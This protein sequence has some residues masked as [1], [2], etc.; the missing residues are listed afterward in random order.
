MTEIFL[1]K[2]TDLTKFLDQGNK[3]VYAG[4]MELKWIIKQSVFRDS[5]INGGAKWKAEV[6]HNAVR[7]GLLLGNREE[8]RSHKVA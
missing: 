1:K 2:K 7:C 4:Q 6:H 3:R 5:I 8:R